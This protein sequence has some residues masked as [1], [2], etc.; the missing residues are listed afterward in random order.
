MTNA[1][2]G[3]ELRLPSAAKQHNHPQ[4]LQQHPVDCGGRI[5][6]S[7]MDCG[8]A[9]TGPSPIMDALLHSSPGNQAVSS[10]TKLSA[11]AQGNQ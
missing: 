9:A 4:L 8:A 3:V 10:P 11:H 6:D 1:P 5:P 2:A 7:D